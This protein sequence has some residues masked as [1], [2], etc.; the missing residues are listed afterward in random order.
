MPELS[1]KPPPPVFEHHIYALE[2][3]GYT[4]LRRQLDASA[5]EELRACADRGLAALEAAIRGGRVEKKSD[6]YRTVRCMYVWGDACVQLLEHNAIHSLASQMM[7]SYQ[8]WDMAVLAVFPSLEATLPSAVGWHRDFAGPHF[9]TEIPSYLWFF[10]CLND[11][12]PENGATWVVPGSHRVTSRHERP[13]D[14]VCAEDSLEQYPSR[15]QLCACA[16]DILVLNPTLIHTP[17]RNLTGE[18]RLVLFVGVCHTAVQPIADHWAI[19]GPIIQERASER[20]R[21]MLQGGRKPLATTWP[22]LPEGWQTAG[23]LP[24]ESGA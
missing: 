11:L 7:G 10:V 21:R 12:T 22:L 18:P 5:V 14:E 24:S 16:G 15:Y 17:G 2:V 20:V 23:N 13:L 1:S 8:L 4:C 6:R 3:S 19:A 9:G